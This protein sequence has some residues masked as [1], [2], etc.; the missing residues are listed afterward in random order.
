MRSEFGSYLKSLRA[1]HLSRWRTGRHVEAHLRFPGMAFHEALSRV[2]YRRLF[3]QWPDLDYP[4]TISEKLCW[5][6][7]ND[8]RPINA[9]I[10]DKYRMRGY[11]EA[12][13]LG[14]LLVDIH[15]VWDAADK[16]AFDALPD[17]YALKVTNGSSWNVI[18]RPGESIDVDAARRKLDRWMKTEM[19]D[20]KGE[21]YYAASPPRIIAERYLENEAG[22]MP[23]YKLYVMNGETRIVHYCDSRFN[24]LRRIFMLPD[25]TPAP[26]TFPA[27][28]EFGALPERPEALDEMVRL[29]RI[30]AQDFA[31]VRVDFYIHQGRLLL[32][33]LSLN[34][35][36]GYTM[37]K[38][39]EWNLKIGDWL[40]LPDKASIAG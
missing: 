38:P 23:D 13:G 30:L 33:E 4:R 27:F 15:G 36:G 39:D 35:G 6:K 19:A 24:G 21:W 20:N 26:F 17:A 9:V 28:G 1:R 11:A 5:L 8:R 31:M 3:G 40:D 16:V 22:D 25:W 34:P 12:L 7:I 10:T 18:K 37:F 14:H 32:G 2:T 29:A